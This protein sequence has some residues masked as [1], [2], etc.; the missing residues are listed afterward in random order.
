[1]A[2]GGVMRSRRRLT[3]VILA[4]S[5]LGTVTA[6]DTTVTF[7]GGT[8]GWTGPQG[9]GGSTFI[10][11]AGGN[12]GANLR[13]IFNDFG[14]TF[15]TDSNPAFVFDYTTSRSVTL[16]VDLRVSVIS[17]FG[18]PVSRPWLVELRDFDGPPPGWP[19]VSVWYKFADVS[20]A[21]HGSWTSFSVTIPDTAARELPPGWGGTGAEDPVTFEPELPRDRTFASVLAGVDEIAFTTLEPGFFFGFTDFDV[22]IDNLTI[23]DPLA[24]PGESSSLVLAPGPSPGTLSVS[25]QATCGTAQEYGIYQ[26]VLGDWDS[27]LRIDCFDA[28]GDLTENVNVGGGDHYYLVVPWRDDVEGSYGRDSDGDERPPSTVP[29]RQLQDLGACD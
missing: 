23:A 12:P 13:T 21:A 19:Y 6:A 7:D 14:I 18:S 24:V 2:E 29:C 28:G 20:A 27:H 10:E 25:W 9:P 8:E 5:L 26:G 16:G 1:M 22:R 3:I 4:F 15:S 11:P 17:F